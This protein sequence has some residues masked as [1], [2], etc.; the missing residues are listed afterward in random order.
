MKELGY[1]SSRI[2]RKLQQNHHTTIPQRSTAQQEGTNQRKIEKKNEQP[3]IQRGEHD[4][5]D[6]QQCLGG[7]ERG[8]GADLAVAAPR[9]ADPA[10]AALGQP[11]QYV[12]P[13]VPQTGSGWKH[14]TGHSA[15]SPSTFATA[16]G[17]LGS[18]AAPA[19]V[20]GASAGRRRLG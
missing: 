19:V 5:G 18:A 9:D 4:C 14:H 12:T 16:Q 11:H 17:S 10:Q 20:V 1:H 2:L 6:E 13:S 3:Y 7:D 15:T 8:A